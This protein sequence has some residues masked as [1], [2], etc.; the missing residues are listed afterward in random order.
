[1]SDGNLIKAEQDR[2][3]NLDQQID[4][5]DALGSA[6]QDYSEVVFNQVDEVLKYMSIL[7]KSAQISLQSEILG[8]LSAIDSENIDILV[9]DLRIE[10][11]EWMQ[12]V[13]AEVDATMDYLNVW[14]GLGLDFN[15]QKEYALIMS[16]N[17]VEWAFVK[18]TF[19]LVSTIV[20]QLPDQEQVDILLKVF[21]KL[22]YGQREN[23]LKPTFL[24]SIINYNVESSKTLLAEI[25]ELENT[26]IQAREGI[27][28]VT[29]SL[30]QA[31]KLNNEW[32]EF[33][34]DEVDFRAQ[35]LRV[36]LKNLSELEE[37]ILMKNRTL[38][39]TLESTLSSKFL[40]LQSLG[41]DSS[42]LNFASR[43]KLVYPHNV[44]S[45][46][47]SFLTEPNL[48]TSNISEFERALIDDDFTK[49]WQVL[50][51]SMQQVP[52][53]DA[54][55]HYTL[56][57]LFR[58]FRDVYQST[59][60][61][62]SAEQDLL[63]TISSR[64]VDGSHARGLLDDGYKLVQVTDFD[65]LGEV[66][67]EDGFQ[68]S[69]LANLFL[70]KQIDD[71][72]F[73]YVSIYPNGSLNTQNPKMSFVTGSQAAEMLKQQ[74]EN[75]EH[76]QTLMQGNPVISEFRWAVS[77]VNFKLN[78]LR[79]LL[80]G[81]MQGEKTQ[82]AVDLVRNQAVEL[83]SLI[84]DIDLEAITDGVISELKN[85][86][87][88]ANQG[89]DSELIENIQAAQIAVGQMHSSLNIE[90]LNRMFVRIQSQDFS[91]D[92]WGL[93]TL[94]P[95][96]GAISAGVGAVI[97]AFPTGG[98]SLLGL[99][100]V[101]TFGGLV[102]YEAVV[103]GVELTTDI[104][105]RTMLGAALMGSTIYNSET[106][107]YEDV[108]IYELSKVYGRQ[109]VMGTIHTLAL[110]GVG[111]LLGGYLSK[112]A[113]K[114]ALTKGWRGGVAK[115][116]G[117]IPIISSS[118]AELLKRV[119]A[120][121][122]IQRFTRE[123]GEELVEESVEA[124]A[125]RINGW[126]GLVASVL[127]CT[128]IANVRYTLAGNAVVS[129]GIVVSGNNL[130]STFTYD[131][132][133]RSEIEQEIAKKYPDLNVAMDENGVVSATHE[134]EAQKKD[135]TTVKR[136]VKM[137]FL[138]SSVP[139]F[140]RELDSQTLEGT[141]LT[142]KE[143]YG[144]EFKDGKI[145]YENEGGVENISV[146]KYLQ[147]RGGILLDDNTQVRFGN[148]KYQIE[149]SI[150]SLNVNLDEESAAQEAADV[151][152]TQTEEAIV[153]ND[154]LH[155]EIGQMLDINT[156]ALRSVLPVVNVD[157]KAFAEKII[158][159]DF[160][161]YNAKELA[162][163]MVLSVALKDVASNEQVHN[164]AKNLQAYLAGT[165]ANVEFAPA[166]LQLRSYFGDLG[167]ASFREKYKDS[168]DPE[169]LNSSWDFGNWETWLKTKATTEELRGVFTELGVSGVASADVSAM[170]EQGVDIANM[171]GQPFG[172][173]AHF[174]TPA[175]YAVDLD[176][177][178]GAVVKSPIAGEVVRVHSLAYDLNLEMMDYFDRCKAEDADLTLEGVKKH[179]MIANETVAANNLELAQRFVNDSSLD[180]NFMTAVVASLI[181][182][183][184]SPKADGITIKDEDGNLHEIYH[185]Q[186]LL[187]V[188]DKVTVGQPIVRLDYNS[189]MSSD[190]HVHYEVNNSEE[191]PIP[192]VDISGVHLYD[193][194]LPGL[195]RYAR[196]IHT[197]DIRTR[198]KDYIESNLDRIEDCLSRNGV[199][200]TRYNLSQKVNTYFFG[201]YVYELPSDLMKMVVDLD[202]LDSV[203]EKYPIGLTLV[204][205]HFADAHEQLGPLLQEKPNLLFRVILF[206]TSWFKNV[207]NVM[208]LKSFLEKVNYDGNYMKKLLFK[209]KFLSFLN[210]KFY[211]L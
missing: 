30:I 81:L 41:D 179:M 24:E 176:I 26:Q 35:I 50:Q 203:S 7:D 134:I 68:R 137:E 154:N 66:S 98:A 170:Y 207:D 48:D 156:D 78:N 93:Q 148:D 188:G 165:Q 172:L 82:D 60:K 142:A 191:R 86:R 178:A 45:V 144:L 106:N 5:S 132:D 88:L 54:N 153:Q 76:L 103:S 126:A 163:C 202:L 27:N 124:G 102:G 190:P 51:A 31:A 70:V 4:K 125:Q 196:S 3:N 127:V 110:M 43:V 155:A 39:S 33:G 149:S 25:K 147:S 201:H 173:A 107:E 58:T 113:Q 105:T 18:D 64:F 55:N 22:V 164:F 72:S 169:N 205:E 187:K 136:T 166:F 135:G 89:A 63:S 174:Y 199:N 120:Q 208:I 10:T 175:R 44:P 83:Q 193:N 182:F 101:G 130:V 36:A 192:I 32:F 177:Q 79:T 61:K 73:N 75:H 168:I 204:E 53:L 46:I 21:S 158:S 160:S 184:T 84:K 162:T 194:N 19:L 57:D 180:A 67:F 141:S 128:R 77:K 100:A 189:G 118:E 13:D 167:Y 211:N 150:G 29:R 104:E 95:I 116:L 198:F 117:K 80:S 171:I 23:L 85:L 197:I 122:F 17:N 59:S 146:H 65:I 52:I 8:I 15:A 12:V 74:S 121:S 206:N 2:I 94:L 47:D 185:A 181:D 114:H 115:G 157:L 28:N 159:Q 145:Y 151:H 133:S 90:G 138:P 9:M 210:S 62:A 91:V 112:F 143:F 92:N 11:T 56:P 152:D 97:L 139:R 123:F 195:D 183:T 40:I 109:F 49:A 186:A 99:A 129:Q 161:N 119:G 69:F 38:D 14:F 42:L 96:L 1:M 37:Q 209:H 87:T 140:I 200:F 131:A 108:D 71:G 111:R 6:T 34:D 16:Q 20:N